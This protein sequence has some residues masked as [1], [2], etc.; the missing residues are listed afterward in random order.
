LKAF[1]S[2]DEEH[3]RLVI[4]P[5]ISW[6][7]VVADPVRYINAAW[8]L[9]SKPH[10]ARAVNP[11]G[12]FRHVGSPAPVV[13]RIGDE[14]WGRCD[15]CHGDMRLSE[16]CF[17][18]RGLYKFWYVCNCGHAGS[19][20]DVSG[21]IIPDAIR[22]AADPQHQAV[23]IWSDLDERRRSLPQSQG[24]T[25]LR[26]AKLMPVKQ[27]EELWLVYELPSKWKVTYSESTREYKTTSSDGS[28]RVFA[29]L[30]ALASWLGSH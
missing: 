9:D 8:E 2:Y 12:V 26:Q 17:E 15:K 5:G 28:Q 23:G 24:K 10:A 14:M 30:E 25:L 4:Y 19:I 27:G 1:G 29:D 3:M 13:E 11:I 21:D 7:Q 16:P 20:S 18:R 22:A 6:S